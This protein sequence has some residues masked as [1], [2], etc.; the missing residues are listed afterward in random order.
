MGTD[1]ESAC[2]IHVN[3]IP[4]NVFVDMGSMAAALDF[5]DIVSNRRNSR[6][7]SMMLSRSSGSDSEGEDHDDAHRFANSGDLTPLSGPQRE[8]LQRIHQQ[9]L[10]DLNLSVDYLSGVSSPG[11]P[12]PRLRKSHGVTQVRIYVTCPKLTC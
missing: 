9:E 6:E 8:A 2:S 5:L 4:L 11:G 10:A 7:S 3:I 12:S 1:S